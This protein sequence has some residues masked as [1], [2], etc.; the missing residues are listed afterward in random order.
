MNRKVT[1]VIGLLIFTMLALAAG[2]A[3]SGGPVEEGPNFTGQVT[4][5]QHIGRGDVVGSVLVEEKVVTQDGEYL[6]KYVITVTGETLLFDERG[7]DRS[8]ETFDALAI[9]QR[10]QVWFSGPIK[11]SYP[12]QV[13]A[14][15]IVIVG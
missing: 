7:G 2:C 14:G 6:D 1:V 9:G 10:V 11:E 15:Q 12:M 4:D 13:D 3:G 5:V 8:P